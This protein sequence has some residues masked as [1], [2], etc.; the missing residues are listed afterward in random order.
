[1]G[2][3]NSGNFCREHEICDPSS[4]K[5]SCLSLFWESSVD[6]SRMSMDHTYS[7]LASGLWHW[8]C[9]SRTSWWYG[10]FSCWAHYSVPLQWVF[11]WE[12][13][14]DLPL[15]C[16][17]YDNLGRSHT[18]WSLFRWLRIPFVSMVWPEIHW[19]RFWEKERGLSGKA[20]NTKDLGMILILTLGS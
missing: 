2:L 12:W 9:V 7:L 13:R 4:V 14:V 3:D 15:G 11:R 6:A 18:L 1:M 16:Q 10:C 5:P 19:R 20:F 8:R 17:R